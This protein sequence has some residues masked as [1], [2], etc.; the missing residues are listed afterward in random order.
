M[1]NR[2]FLE[3]PSAQDA[4]I[5]EADVIEYGNIN[6][7]TRPIVRLKN[8]SIKTIFSIGIGETNF[9]CSSKWIRE[10]ALNIK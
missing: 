7:L 6:L 8:G 9:G 10:I 5:P 4:G 2:Y 3:Y 1:A